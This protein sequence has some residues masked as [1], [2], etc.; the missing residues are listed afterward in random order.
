M[1][2]AGYEVRVLAEEGESFEQN[3][4]TLVEFI[5][6]DLRWCQGNMQY[7]HFLQMPGLRPVSRYQLGLA[8]LM[9]IASPAWIGL[10]VIGTAA[11]EPK[12][13]QIAFD[14]GA[15]RIYCA[16][17]ETLSVV[18]ASRQGLELLGHVA[19]FAGAKNVAVDL[20]SAQGELVDRSSN[21]ERLA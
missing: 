5:R 14:S 3:P 21:V 17:S 8:I 12:V 15:R 11:I 18:Q 16:A 2:R 7:R 13:D 10:L 20:K 4:P 19:S 6:R 9:F 1:R